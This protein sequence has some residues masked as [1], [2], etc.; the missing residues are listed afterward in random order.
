MIERKI[1]RDRLRGDPGEAELIGL[2]LDV[3]RFVANG[4]HEPRAAL[5]PMKDLPAV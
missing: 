5:F 2:L 4:A 1:I 3:D